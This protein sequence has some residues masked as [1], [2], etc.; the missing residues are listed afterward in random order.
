[1]IYFANFKHFFLQMAYELLSKSRKLNKRGGP[2]KSGE[3][4]KFFEKKSKLGGCLLGTQE[5]PL[6][7]RNISKYFS[8]NDMKETGLNGY[9]YN[10]WVDYVRINV[11]AI[12]D[13]HKYLRNKNNI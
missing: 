5:Y 2:N 3:V 11:G 4:G 1:M 8:A 13:I 9:A 7:F 12:Q 10:F 6:Y